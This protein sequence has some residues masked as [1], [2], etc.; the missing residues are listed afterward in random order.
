M[1]GQSERF[2]V[3]FWLLLFAKAF[4]KNVKS[5]NIFD[6]TTKKRQ[7]N[8]YTI[9]NAVN[10]HERTPNVAKIVSLK[11]NPPLLIFYIDSRIFGEACFE[12]HL[13]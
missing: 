7:H 6:I 10:F 5:N 3:C 2:I 9:L 13:G 8:A 1:I 4:V 11:I 12:I